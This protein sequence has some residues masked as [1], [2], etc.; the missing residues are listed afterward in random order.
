MG[1]GQIFTVV[2]EKT[3]FTSG[4]LHRYPSIKNFKIIYANVILSTKITKK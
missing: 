4:I 2:P 3:E 1:D